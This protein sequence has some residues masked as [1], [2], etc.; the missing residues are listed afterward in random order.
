MGK[1][2]VK[3]LEMIFLG[4]MLSVGA[5]MV[6]S[7]LL[8]NTNP[9]SLDSL[10]TVSRPFEDAPKFTLAERNEFVEEQKE[11]AGYDEL[12]P[13]A[14]ETWKNVAA[15]LYGKLGAY[16]LRFELTDDPE[17]NCAWSNGREGGCYHQGGPFDRMIF[18]SPNIDKPN[19]EFITY[20]EYSHYLQDREGHE[21]SP[22]ELQGHTR[23]SANKECDAD[24]RALQL[25]GSW[26]PGFELQCLKTGLLSNELTLEN[27]PHLEAQLKAKI[28]PRT[29]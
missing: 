2:A 20:H 24:L 7:V 26:V 27:L 14:Q 4:A 29:R 15:V 9:F 18:I 23:F 16:Q 17:K 10:N 28:H 22:Q 5:F 25:R 6:S 8:G 19:A 12:S 1:R 3:H 13:A 21:L 11:L